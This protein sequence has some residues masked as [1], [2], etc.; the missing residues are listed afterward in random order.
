MGDGRW[1][2]GVSAR[3]LLRNAWG[4]LGILLAPGYPIAVLDG[5]RFDET[6][7]TEALTRAGSAELRR[8]VA[9]ESHF[10][11]TLHGDTVVVS[12][13]SV[14]LTE[15]ADGRSRTIDTDGFVG[16]RFRLRLDSTGAATLWQRPF[17]PD[18]MADVSDLS[19]AM[20][21]FFPPLPPTMALGA[22]TSDAAGR[23]W[24][25]LADS[26]GSQRFRWSAL[27]SRD[28]AQVANDTVPVLLEESTREESA[29]AWSS[30]RGPLTW[31][32]QIE[33]NVTTRLRGTTVRATI[34]QRIDVRRSR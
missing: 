1:Q 9:R 20:D 17:I 4:L 13:D 14:T 10:G 28:T 33:S 29:L 31:S 8:L 6:I 26:S 22:D 12:A 19:R 5:A 23:H 3:P 18:G 16:G 21:D 25:R 30:A 24:H 34:N 27:V 2:G 15:V 11:V 32:R 7:R